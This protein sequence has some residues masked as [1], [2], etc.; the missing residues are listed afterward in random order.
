MSD[1]LLY[2]VEEAAKVLGIGRTRTF[3]LIARGE[4]RS[5]R[6]GT[7]RRVPAAALAEYV[8]RLCQQDQQAS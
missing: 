6:I 2:R 5:V 3:K 8:E 1:Q 4:L 7:S